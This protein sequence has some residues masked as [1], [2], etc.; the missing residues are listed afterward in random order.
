MEANEFWIHFGKFALGWILIDLA[1]A[2]WHWGK[3]HVAIGISQSSLIIIVVLSKPHG[4]VV[5]RRGLFVV[6]YV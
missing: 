3:R 1:L 2:A 4:L 6:K 5:N